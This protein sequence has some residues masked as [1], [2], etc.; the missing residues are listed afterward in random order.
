MSVE[1]ETK[2]L[3]R[4]RNRRNAIDWSTV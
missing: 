3:N 4:D 2:Q 1:A